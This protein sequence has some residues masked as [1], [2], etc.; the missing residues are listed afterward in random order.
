MELSLPYK[1]S[2]PTSRERGEIMTLPTTVERVP[3][4]TASGVNSRIR[5][6]TEANVLYYS[7]QE[8]EVIRQRLRELEA[9]W[10]IERTLEA[11]AGAAA[12]I[13]VVLGATVSRK[14]LI[15]P[16]V[17]AGFLLQHA[18]QGWCPPLPVFRQLGIRTQSEIDE[19]RFALRTQLAKDW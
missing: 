8:P 9:E 7:A 19:E 18:L 6:Q 4:S 14:W 17:V 2:E 12:L 13:G 10:D 1:R 3:E 5:R 16:G 15:L 11:N